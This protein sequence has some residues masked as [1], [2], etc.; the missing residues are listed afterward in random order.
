[1]YQKKLDS[2]LDI[3]LGRRIGSDF[4]PFLVLAT[5]AYRF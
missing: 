2:L 1:V 3:S 4:V 5:Y